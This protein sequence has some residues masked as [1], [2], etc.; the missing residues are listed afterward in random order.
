M[1]G[2]SVTILFHHSALVYPIAPM[3]PITLISQHD[4]HGNEKTR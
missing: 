4:D 1:G 3:T 2:F